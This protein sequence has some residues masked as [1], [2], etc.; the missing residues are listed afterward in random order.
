MSNH[1][2]HAALA[3][4]RDEELRRLAPRPEAIVVRPLDVAPVLSIL[5]GVAGLLA[6]ALPSI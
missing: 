6:V 4:Q 1:Q 5:A 3:R 2:I